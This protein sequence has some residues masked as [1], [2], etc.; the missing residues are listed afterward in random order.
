MYIYIYIHTHWQPTSKSIERGVIRDVTDNE[1][2][3]K[4]FNF[5]KSSQNVY[6]GKGQNSQG[7]K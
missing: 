5:F 6:E 4:K 1:N 2:Q 7:L 3:T